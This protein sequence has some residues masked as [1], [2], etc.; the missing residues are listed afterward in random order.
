MSSAGTTVRDEIKA[1]ETEARA[2]NGKIEAAL[3]RF[4][5]GEDSPELNSHYDALFVEWEAVTDRL[6]A[7]GA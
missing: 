4:A 3:S 6:V 1:A 5:L 2:V 7:L